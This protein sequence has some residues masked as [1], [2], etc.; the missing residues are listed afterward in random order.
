MPSIL[1]GWHSMFQNISALSFM[2]TWLIGNCGFLTL[3][4]STYDIIMSIHVT[5]HFYIIFRVLSYETNLFDVNISSAKELR[6]PF[7][8]CH[9]I[10]PAR[11]TLLD[12]H[13]FLLPLPYPMRERISRRFWRKGL[14]QRH[15]LRFIRKILPSERRPVFVKSFN[16][17]GQRWI[18]F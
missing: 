15:F 18:Q 12:S 13:F 5:D 4:M 17:R 2:F 14:I 16:V 9:F 3:P 1:A 7:I 8:L 10:F 6:V 11:G